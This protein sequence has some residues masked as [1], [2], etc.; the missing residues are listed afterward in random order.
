MYDDGDW[1]DWSSDGSS[2]DPCSDGSCDDGS[3]DDGSTDDGSS[4]AA[5]QQRKANAASW[6]PMPDATNTLR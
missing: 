6:A 2:D 5:P 1:G 4:R 3:T